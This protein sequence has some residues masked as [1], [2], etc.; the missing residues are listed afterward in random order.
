MTGFFT[1]L[2]LAT[3]FFGSLAISKHNQ[4]KRYALVFGNQASSQKSSVNSTKNC[5]VHHDVRQPVCV[6]VPDTR[7]E[8]PEFSACAECPDCGFLATHYI[9]PI[10][11]QKIKQYLTREC[12]NCG[13][14]WTELQ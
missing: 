14:H 5:S 9:D 12:V 1:L 7:S 2:A 3:V 11:E 10:E 13:W 6:A 8:P 4:N